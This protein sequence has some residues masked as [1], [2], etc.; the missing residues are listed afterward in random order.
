MYPDGYL[1]KDIVNRFNAKG[2]TTRLGKKMSYNIVQYMLTNRKYIGEF[3]YND[4]VIPD[5]VPAIVSKDLFERVQ[6]R[7]AQN[8]HAPARHKAEDDYLL[9]TNVVCANGHTKSKL[10]LKQS[11]QCKAKV[12]NRFE[13]RL[14]C[15]I[16]LYRK[17][18]GDFG[19]LHIR[20]ITSKLL[21]FVFAVVKHSGEILGR[22]VAF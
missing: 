13:S 20:Q 17:Q 2:I 12:E 6:R 8:K 7:M 14:F 19:F 4:I 15:R 16:Y 3:R 11:N 5:A 21:R 18:N 10:E 22:I 9:T 1:I